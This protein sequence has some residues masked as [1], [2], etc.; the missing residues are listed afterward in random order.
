MRRSGCNDSRTQEMAKSDV[1]LAR[2]LAYL[3]FGAHIFT[4]AMWRKCIVFMCVLC[5]WMKCID[6]AWFVFAALSVI[7]VIIVV[8]VRQVSTQQKNRLTLAW[9][10]SNKCS[11][12][13]ESRTISLLRIWAA[14][15]IRHNNH[16]FCVKERILFLLFSCCLSILNGMLSLEA[17]R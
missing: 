5:I 9:N 7:L 12:Y 14:K 6:L 2:I 4:I 8:M 13:S 11:S 16:K 3:P 10:K 1:S 17:K 15:K